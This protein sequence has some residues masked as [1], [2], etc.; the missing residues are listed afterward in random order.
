MRCR[1]TKPVQIFC[2]NRIGAGED[3]IVQA[4]N[5]WRG[6]LAP[7]DAHWDQNVSG[8]YVHRK[9]GGCGVDFEGRT[10]DLQLHRATR[11]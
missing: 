8:Y 9:A 11:K 10:A 6:N 3:L 4:A 1:R 5:D 7:P 2:L